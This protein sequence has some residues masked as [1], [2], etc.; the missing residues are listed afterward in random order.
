MK[1][2]I[3]GC[4]S[5]GTI[6]GAYVSN[7]DYDVVLIDN[8]KEHVNALNEKGAHVIG[9]KD[10]VTPVHAITVDEMEGIYDVV[11]LLT[12][13]T[14][15]SEVLP[16]LLPHLDDDSVVCALQNGIPEPFVSE[17]VKGNRVVGGA[18]IWSATFKEPGVSILTQDI[19]STKHLFAIGEIDGTIT[20]RI[21]QIKKILEIMGPVEVTDTLMGT[22]YGKLFLNA[23][24]SG[25][26]AA[27]GCTFGGIF[28]N[29]KGAAALSYI[30]NEVKKCCEAEGYVLPPVH[31]Y[32]VE[33]FSLRTKEEYDESQ[34]IIKDILHFAPGG[35]ASMLQD[36]INGR[37][38]EV[39]M[40]DG[41]IS[42][43]GRRHNIPTPFCDAIVDIVTKCENGELSPS[44]ENDIYFK[45]EW[46]EFGL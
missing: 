31:G 38:T 32:P 10:F 9:A 16:K 36:L 17:Y 41:Y 42:L 15:N 7:H 44:M 13:Q 26:S 23:G 19:D 18:V 30:G 8:Y 25:L 46:F 39:K 6:L 33:S 1:V 29:K 4:G 45:D 14:A 35:K 37:K 11:F 3:L 20:D 34:R 43:V 28:E 5:L 12:K 27:L 24:S 22:R 21:M 2:A 40:I